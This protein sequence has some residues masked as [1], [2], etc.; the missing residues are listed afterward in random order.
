MAICAVTTDGDDDRCSPPPLAGPCA[1]GMESLA[2]AAWV[3]RRW[4]ESHP[5]GPSDEKRRFKRVPCGRQVRKVSEWGSGSGPH[6]PGSDAK[7]SERK[8]RHPVRM[9]KLKII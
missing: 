2:A 4:R 9:R 7:G 1:G 5:S 6:K 8:T 3:A